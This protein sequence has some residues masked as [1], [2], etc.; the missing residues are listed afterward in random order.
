MPGWRF[1]EPCQPS[2]PGSGESSRRACTAAA[3]RRDIRTRDVD[4]NPNPAK[5]AGL[6]ALSI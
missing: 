6:G 5:I 4:L 1:W 3:F 2:Q